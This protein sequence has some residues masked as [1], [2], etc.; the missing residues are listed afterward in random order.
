M[1]FIICSLLHRQISFQRMVSANK[2]RQTGWSRLK[3]TAWQTSTICLITKVK[4]QFQRNQPWISKLLNKNKKFLISHHLLKKRRNPR[5]KKIRKRRKV[6][7][8]SGPQVIRAAVKKRSVRK[9]PKSSRRMSYLQK[10]IRK[11]R[12]I[13]AWIQLKSQSSPR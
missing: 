10:S 3:T 6:K 1:E 8:E 13:Q 2:H 4:S 9:R 5:N 7:R 11:T 12:Q